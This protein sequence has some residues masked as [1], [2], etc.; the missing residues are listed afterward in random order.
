MKKHLVEGIVKRHPDGF[1]FL[2]PDDK[3]VDDVYIPR[4]SMA[5][6]MTN[7]RVQVNV[8]Q[9]HW[10]K[11]LSG[12]IVKVIKHATTRVVGVYHGGDGIN[13]FVAD[14]ENRWGY[15]SCYSADSIEGCETWPTRRG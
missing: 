6:V 12:E 9:N 11:R 1:G 5:G 10:D 4:H 3:E 8:E 13:G 2:V 15:E 7:D 14:D